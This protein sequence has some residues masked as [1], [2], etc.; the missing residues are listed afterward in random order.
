ML[1]V[2]EVDVLLALGNGMIEVNWSKISNE[3][4]E[5]SCL[6]RIYLAVTVFAAGKHYNIKLDISNMHSLLVWAIV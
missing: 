3:S 1:L 4:A 6:L 5:T 2:V